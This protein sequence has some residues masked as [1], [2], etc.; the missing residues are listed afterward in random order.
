MKIKLICE[1]CGNI[2]LEKN[3]SVILDTDIGNILP[4]LS[5]E[6]DNISY[7][8]PHQPDSRYLECLECGNI[9]W[10]YSD[11]RNID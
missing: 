8:E 9:T 10:V 5:Y 6:I 7:N 11:E 3:I 1:K 4:E 2:I